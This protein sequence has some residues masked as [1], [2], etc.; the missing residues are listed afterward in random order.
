MLIPQKETRGLRSCSRTC[1]ELNVTTFAQRPMLPP[2]SLNAMQCYQQ[3]VPLTNPDETHQLVYKYKY[4]C[5]YKYRN[6]VP[7][8]TP[9]PGWS[10]W[11][12]LILQPCT[13]SLQ[14]QTPNFCTWST[15]LS[16]PVIAGNK[17]LQTLHSSK[18]VLTCLLFVLKLFSVANINAI[19]DQIF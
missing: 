8:Q 3:H 13:N 2:C 1:F 6:W 16:D 15:R 11:V 17:F 4:K 19:F 7:T 9:L 10:E 14:L 12:Q 5:K 18:N